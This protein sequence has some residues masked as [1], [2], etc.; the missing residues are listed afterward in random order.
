MLRR[1][2][3]TIAGCVILLTAC[4]QKPPEETKFVLLV[5]WADGGDGYSREY[6]N[7]NACDVAK[8]IL[9]HDYAQRGY[10]NA[11]A[12]IESNTDAPAEPRPIA[13]C[14]PA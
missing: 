1:G 6:P 5:H 8:G 14:I 13:V 9:L 12:Q 2:R 7:M 10:L 11:K 3:F 4:Q